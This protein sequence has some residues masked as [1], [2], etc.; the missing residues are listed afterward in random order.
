MSAPLAL[1]LSVAMHV[2]W[3]LMARHLPRQANPLW[4]VL[5]AHLVLFGPWGFRELAT[6]VDWTPGMALLLAVSAA[7]NAVYF[8][9]L[10]RAYEHAPVALVY[11]VVRSSPLLIAL[12][13]T[14][15]FGQHLP[16][17]AWAGIVVSVL[18]LLVMASGSG[19][20][21][22]GHA[23]P[24]ALLA[25]LSTSVYSLSDKAA[26]AHIPTFMGLMG[27]L[28]VGYLASWIAITW[29]MRR[30]S[31]RWVPEQRIGA[32]PMLAGGLCIG[33]AYALVIHAM[34]ALAAAEVVAYTNAGIVLATVSSVYL[35][36]ENEDWK[37]RMLGAAVIML[38]LMLLS[39]R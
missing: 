12:W 38:G 17:L 32:I 11:P 37:R 31:R 33:V 15:F 9:G 18:G 19:R 8:T 4:W 1:A 24:W 30:R 13:G 6:T 3:N 23:L 10:A 36:G 22:G 27:F 39:L 29:R 14:L 7:A 28:S 5:L 20:G 21:N 26:T 16:P 25:M 2:I 34:R 35:F